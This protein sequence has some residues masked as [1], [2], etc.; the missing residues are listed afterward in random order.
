MEKQVI[1]LNI[2]DFAVGVERVAD[3]R[4]RTRP[5][6]IAP[7][8]GPRS[9]VF[10]MSDEA[11]R[12]GVRKGMSL[13][14]AK[15]LARTAVIIPPK[16]DLYERA[17]KAFVKHAYPFSRLVE[18][19]NG[20]GHLFM[21]VTGTRRLF[22]FPQDV[23]ERVRRSII[24]DIRLNPIWS[25]ASNKLVAK[26][27]TR[28]VKPLGEY[29]VNGG[30]EEKFI[31]PI[32]LNLLPGLFGEEIERFRE[33]NIVTAGA[34]RP[35]SP[36]QLDVLFGKRART[37]FEKVRGIDYSQLL[38]QNDGKGKIE[39]GH[40]FKPDTND[41]SLLDSALYGCV[42]RV[43]MELR[44]RRLALREVNI[45]VDYC[46]GNR[47]HK[48]SSASAPV[49]SNSDIFDIALKALNSAWTRRV[50][51]RHIRIACEKLSPME[52]QLDFFTVSGN[53]ISAP[54]PLDKAFDSIRVRFGKGAVMTGRTF[55]GDAP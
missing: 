38:C 16:F 25:V 45:L 19:G 30:D 27:A 29:I 32:R 28:L 37:I 12:E 20:D 18:H 42:E 39:S 17:M 50:R 46:D 54:R 6:I 8:G 51:I 41:A 43:G 9:T 34:V 36:V 26:V 33:L 10:D 3:R 23:A 35:F 15:R 11:F 14:R 40:T 48:K 24:G 7:D 22:G 55:G 5:L 53:G 47:V 4:F 2:A 21:D 52:L 1:H 13:S 31:E 49:S 44:G